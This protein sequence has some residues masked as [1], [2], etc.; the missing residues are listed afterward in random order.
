[1]HNLVRQEVFDS[2]QTLIVKIGSNVLT[3]DDDQLDRERI[4]HLADQIDRLLETGRKVVVVSSGAVAAGIGVLELGKR[5]SSLPELQAAAAAGQS[6]LMK[7]WGECLEASG[8]HVGQILL[9]VNDFRNRRRYLNVRNT[10]RTL[11]GYNVVPILNENDSVSIQEIAV[12]DNDQLAAL[13]ATLVPA[14]LLVILSGVDGLFDGSPSDPESQVIDMV[15]RPDESLLAHVSSEQSSRGRGGMASKLTAIL[16]AT[17]TGESVILANGRVDG[18][19]DRISH[20]QPTGTLFVGSG[21]VIP[22][23]KKWIAQA[24]KPEGRL[25]IDDGAGRAV[26]E[27]GR[28]LLAVGIRTVEGSFDQGA[29]VELV[30]PS[31]NVIG[32]GLVNYSAED[33]RRI[34]GCQSAQIAECLGHVPYR[35]VIHRDN[36]IAPE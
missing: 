6:H 24:S 28:S 3:R 29:S 10:I 15:E 26:R 1:M 34:A 8:H 36:L 16:S 22:A 4:Q 5:P 17:S 33:I 11:F 21:A 2:C 18:V 23:W 19:L 20:G 35:E 30:A 32:R 12:G 31:G 9:T 14:P 7:T 13:I 27:Q 25:L